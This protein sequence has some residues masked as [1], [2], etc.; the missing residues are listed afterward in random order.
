MTGAAA[1]A[2]G[3]TIP[4]M[5]TPGWYPNP[6]G[7]NS[8]RYWDGQQWGQVD[9]PP[10]PPAKRK[11]PI[12]QKAAIGVVGAFVALA[13]CGAVF[14]DSEKEEVAAEGAAT[15]TSTT[16]PV[17]ATTP[18]AAPAAPAS[19]APTSAVP[20]R[21]PVDYTSDPRCQPGEPRYDAMIGSGLLDGSLTLANTQMIIDDGVVFY[22]ASTVRPDGKFENRS[23]V[24]V[25]DTI[26]YS[27]TGG[28]RKTTSWS[29]ASD[30]LRIF[31]DDERIQ[32][33]DNC[34]ANLTRN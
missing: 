25:I 16:R 2:R 15:P 26:P 33:V 17:A 30:R 9:A 28:A 13:G 24:W 10:P 5:T 11:M 18:V 1:S 3:A 20:A 34:V 27:S 22:G 6:D 21:P 31:P 12:W 8:R 14:G 29:K 19:A 7:S 23:D 4:A 32:A